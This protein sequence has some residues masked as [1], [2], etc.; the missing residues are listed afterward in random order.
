M[1]MLIRMRLERACLGEIV[2]ETDVAEAAVGLARRRHPDLII[3]DN[4]LAGDRTGLEVVRELKAVEPSCRIVFYSATLTGE[5]GTGALADVDAVVSK[6]EPVRALEDA[7]RNIEVL[8]S[9]R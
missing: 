7:V 6:L 5:A 8:F 9:T 2:G 4:M 3:I 1:R